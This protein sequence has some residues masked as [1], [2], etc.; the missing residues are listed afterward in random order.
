MA[1][2]ANMGSLGYDDVGAHRAR[3]GH[4]RR[5][6][7]VATA[8]TSTST[9]T[10]GTAPDALATAL[11]GKPTPVYALDWA[12]TKVATIPAVPAM[13]PRPT[14]PL[15]VQPAL[16]AGAGGSSS[17]NAAGDPSR[18]R[19]REREREKD[20]TPQPPP[21]PAESI[22]SGARWPRPCRRCRPSGRRHRHSIGGREGAH[23]AAAVA[24]ARA[25]GV[26]RAPAGRDGAAHL[27]RAVRADGEGGGGP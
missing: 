7:R 11:A 19:Q 16:L 5:R 21:R 17:T 3:R 24:A 9:S 12:H 20:F 2:K 18:A 27:A 22:H 25:A 8:T 13:P 4:L 10:F 15:R 14:Q 23:V 1:K 26:A 6:A